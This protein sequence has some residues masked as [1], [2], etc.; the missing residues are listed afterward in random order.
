MTEY[1]GYIPSSEFRLSVVSSEKKNIRTIR[2]PRIY[3]MPFAREYCD[4]IEE[5]KSSCSG[6]PELP[7]VLPP[8]VVTFSWLKEADTTIWRAADL[9]NVF[10]YLR[11]SK[12][13]HIPQD[14]QHLVPMAMDA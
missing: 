4:M 12:R 10:N 8:G 1:D 13:L 6:Q 11:R 9:P 3:P 5:M 7:Q 14:W 2:L